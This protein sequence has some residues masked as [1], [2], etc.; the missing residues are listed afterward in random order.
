MFFTHCFIIVKSVMNKRMFIKKFL[1]SNRHTAS[2]EKSWPGSLGSNPS[3]ATPLVV[4][5]EEA[6]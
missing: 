6:T 2:R 1:V 4:C 5:L 3:S